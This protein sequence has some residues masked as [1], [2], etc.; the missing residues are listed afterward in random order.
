VVARE[1]RST[2]VIVPDEDVIFILFAARQRV[3]KRRVI[4]GALVIKGFKF[5][6]A[7]VPFIGLWVF[8]TQGE[9]QTQQSHQCSSTRRTRSQL[10]RPYQIL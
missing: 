3:P 8:S 7:R 1:V 2:L 10:D 4:I 9:Q 6:T 5:V